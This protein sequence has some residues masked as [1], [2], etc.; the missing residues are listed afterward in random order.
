MSDTVEQP[1]SEED[2]TKAQAQ[3][4]LGDL[5]S[6]RVHPAWSRYYL[7][8]IREKIEP[9]THALLNDRMDQ[10]ARDNLLTERKTYVEILAMLDQDEQGNRSILGIAQP[11]D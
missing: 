11:A 2:R 1:L 9:L 5:L 6:L 8:R 4:D 10:G 7:R 3:R